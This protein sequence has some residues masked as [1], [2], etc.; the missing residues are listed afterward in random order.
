[1]TTKKTPGI[2]RRSVLAAGLAGATAATLAACGGGDD[3]AE[4]TGGDDYTPGS[5]KLK[6]EMAPETEG[7][8]YPDGYVGPK[9]RDLE[10]FGDGKTEYTILSQ[11][12]PDLDLATNAYSLAV[13]EKTGVKVKYTTVPAGDDG[14]TKVNAILAGGDLP[15]AM[16]VGQGIFSMSETAVYGDQGMFIPLDKLIDENAPHI[17]DM[18]N[19]FP[20]MRKQVTTPSGKIYALPAMNDCYHCKSAQV[21]TWINSR[22]LDGVG[23][24]APESL[25]EYEALMDEFRAYSDK[26]EGAVLTTAFADSMEYLFDFFL[27]AFLEKPSATMYTTSGNTV[28]KDGKMTFVHE[29]DRFREGTIWIQEQFKKGNFD[30]GIFSYTSEQYTKLGD[31][32]DGPKF[33]IAWG[34]SQFSLTANAVLTDPD[35]VVNIMTPLAPLAGPDGTRFCAWNYYDYAYLNYVITT[36]CPDPV[37][38]IRWADYQY[39]LGLTI[40]VGSGVQGTAWDYA[41][42]GAKGIDGRQAVYTALPGT[43]D[44]KNQAW[45]E[46]GPLYKSGDERLAA[47]VT[48]D[49]PT[50]EPVLYAAGKLYEPYAMPEDM[51]PPNLFYDTDASAQL[52]EIQTNLT[53]AYQQAM[54]DFGTG[55]KD[56]SKDADWQAYL[57]QCKA[58]GVED[59][60]KLQ[61]DAYDKQFG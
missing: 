13:E 46:W 29:D 10:L 31:G 53:N 6:F 16:M 39:E 54:A 17:V 7:V 19:S 47:A 42:E 2:G 58:I 34:Y 59:L 9:A 4:V 3:T 18:F 49:A 60:L 43:E 33:G 40:S 25:E 56:A 50:V 14:K 41:K 22:W 11:T 24:K 44:L 12:D 37:T 30:P 45:R 55:K 5:A 27:G 26:P 38:L 21:R 52:G 20:D 1:M 36:S 35:N 57:E 61:Q 32:A 15:H 23:A 28:L 51:T 8:L 48:D